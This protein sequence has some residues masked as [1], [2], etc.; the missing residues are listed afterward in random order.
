MASA[1][2]W[3]EADVDE[4]GYSIDEG[5]CDDGDPDINPGVKEICDDEIDN[6]CD[7]AIDFEDPEC[8]AC[9][10]CS[11]SPFRA[12]SATAGLLG[13]FLGGLILRRRRA[14]TGVG[15]GLHR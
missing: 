11:A 9:G 10:A 12:S 1:S 13:L 2:E 7:V 4:D 3:T 14:T 8:T 5:D 6:D 15:Q